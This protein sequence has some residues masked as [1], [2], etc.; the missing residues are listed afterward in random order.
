MQKYIFSSFEFLCQLLRPCECPTSMIKYS[1]QKSVEIF[2][3]SSDSVKYWPKFRRLHCVRYGKL[4]K[5]LSLFLGSDPHIFWLRSA[6][7]SM[8]TY[9]IV[10]LFSYVVVKTNLNISLFSLVYFPFLWLLYQQNTFLFVLQIHIY[11]VCKY[12]S[13]LFHN[14]YSK[15]TS[16]LI[17][18][19]KDEVLQYIKL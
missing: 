13:S 4:L 2:G 3:S 11:Y 6:V 8:I 12:Q 10:I 7:G 19:F 14:S 16:P 18:D 9:V 17:L 1:N 5:G 15:A